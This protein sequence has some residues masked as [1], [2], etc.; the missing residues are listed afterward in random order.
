M[1]FHIGSLALGERVVYVHR[2]AG[3]DERVSYHP[4]SPTEKDIWSPQVEVYD[5]Y[6]WFLTRFGVVLVSR[7]DLSLDT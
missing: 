2:Q 5:D 7:T 4:L 6:D 3:R 1:C